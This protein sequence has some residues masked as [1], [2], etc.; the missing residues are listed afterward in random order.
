MERCLDRDGTH[1]AHQVGLV[2]Y[3]IPS[4]SE[5]VLC[6]WDFHMVRGGINPDDVRVRPRCDEIEV[7]TNAR[8]FRN[9]G[10]E[11][12]HQSQVCRPCPQGPHGD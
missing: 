10:L 7:S 6:G 1:Y 3:T 12:M 5:I 9:S 2:Q 4:Q 11:G 8:Q